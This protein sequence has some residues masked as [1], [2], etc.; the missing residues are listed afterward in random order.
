MLLGGAPLGGLVLQRFSLGVQC[1]F[2]LEWCGEPFSFLSGLCCWLKQGEQLRTVVAR[3][4]TTHAID[5]MQD[6][7]G[8]GDNGLPFRFVPCQEGF[9]EGTAM[10]VEAPRA[11]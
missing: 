5:S 10:W 2:S 8:G 1:F 3:S 11:Q 6:L 4:G 9:G 7:A